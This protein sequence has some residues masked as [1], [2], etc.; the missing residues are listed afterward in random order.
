MRE[1][2]DN[3]DAANTSFFNGGLEEAKGLTYGSNKLSDD[4]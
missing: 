4:K 2:D 3:P 1:E